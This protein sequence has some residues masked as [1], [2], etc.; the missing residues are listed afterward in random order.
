[1]DGKGFAVDDTGATSAGS[2]GDMAGAAPGPVAGVAAPR[3]TGQPKSQ[4]AVLRQQYCKKQCDFLFGL[5]VLWPLSLIWQIKCMVLIP[6]FNGVI[7]ALTW[8]HSVGATFMVARR[9]FEIS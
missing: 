4:F 5:S 1:M 6:L 9:G 8:S 7:N 3:V 2:V